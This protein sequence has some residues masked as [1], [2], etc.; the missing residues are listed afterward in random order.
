MGPPSSGALTLGQIMMLSEPFEL[1][2]LGKDNPV[3]WQVLADA[4]RLAF[5]DRGLY[6]ADS[7][8]YNV[9]TGGLLDS[10][11]MRE[12]SQLITPNKALTEV[13]QV[14]LLQVTA[15]A[16]RKIKPLSFLQRRIS[17]LSMLKAMLSP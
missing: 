3:S 12:R 17:T 5:A 1:D 10:S 15:L 8:F 13:Q 16:S 4:S 11:Y 7:D 9:P 6:M 2:K 14:I